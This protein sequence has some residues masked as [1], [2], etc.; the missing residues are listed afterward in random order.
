MTERAVDSQTWGRLRRG[1]RRKE[2]RARGCC[3]ARV[4]ATN[5]SPANPL[6]WHKMRDR[7]FGIGNERQPLP[8]KQRQPAFQSSI[9]HH[10]NAGKMGVKS[11]DGMTKLRAMGRPDMSKGFLMTTMV[12][13]EWT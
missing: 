2:E 13:D 6:A 11:Q 7:D 10:R 1:W 9:K 3:A 5:I 4:A 8:S 12:I